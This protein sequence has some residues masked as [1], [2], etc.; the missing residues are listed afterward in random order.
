MESVQAQFGVAIFSTLIELLYSCTFT[1]AYHKVVSKSSYND[2][3]TVTNRS[4]SIE[5]LQR[6]VNKSS[7]DVSSFI[8]K[9]SLATIA[10]YKVVTMM[11][12]DH[13]GMH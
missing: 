11:S 12:Y 1:D 8:K 2:T 3:V 13:S 9:L 7:E 10:H 5:Y 6:I 4:L